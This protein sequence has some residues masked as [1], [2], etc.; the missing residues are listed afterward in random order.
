MRSEAVLE[1]SL[2][3]VLA[4]PDDEFAVFPWLEAAL[5]AGRDVRCVWMT[6][7]GWG[8]QD[9]RVRQ[10]ESVSVLSDM[11]VA[12]EAM[13]FLGARIP[14]A[15][16]DL[17]NRLDEAVQGL[18]EGYAG[19]KSYAVLI[20]AW[21]G[22]HHDHD[23][24]H[25]AGL[26]LA[27]AMESPAFQYSLYQGKGLRGPLFKVLSPLPE[28]GPAISLT[29]TM[30]QRMRYVLA[31][32]R[33]RSQWKSFLGLLPFYLLKMCFVRL[34][35]VLQETKAERTAER[36]HEGDLLYERRGGPHWSEF[37]MR[38]ERYRFKPV[39]GGC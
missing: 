6:D 25:L 22:G 12:P 30:A 32:L 11:G 9:I 2:L 4:H 14:I 21:E 38:T 5:E 3:V 23:A 17:W 15:D 20:P 35:F 18:I 10:Q 19:L 37:S 13:N 28:N 26:A 36:P 27:H 29:L 31:C 16:G 34:P 24:S 7:G 39:K 33:Y 1:Q 8:G